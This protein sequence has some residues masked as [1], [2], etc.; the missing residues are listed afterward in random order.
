MSI[1]AEAFVLP[2]SGRGTLQ[3]RIRQMVT[4]EWLWC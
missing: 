2:P 4:E 3:Q 1:P